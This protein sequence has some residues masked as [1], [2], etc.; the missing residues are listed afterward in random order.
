MLKTIVVDL[1][2]KGWKIIQTAL[3]VHTYYDQIRLDLM[4]IVLSNNPCGLFIVQQWVTVSPVNIW[5]LVSLNLYDSP[6]VM[7]SKYFDRLGQYCQ[8]Q[9]H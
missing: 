6:Y 9:Y 2:Y 8:L 7:Q 5:L 3:L 1:Y 4:W